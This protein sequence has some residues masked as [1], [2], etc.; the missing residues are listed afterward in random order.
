MVSNAFPTAMVNNKNS[1]QRILTAALVLFV[2]ACSKK[3]ENEINPPLPEALK[4]NYN[5]STYCH[6]DGCKA[7]IQLITYKSKNYFA[8][9]YDQGPLCDLAP[10]SLPIY[11]ENGNE[12]DTDTDLYKDVSTKGHHGDRIWQCTVH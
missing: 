5:D 8:L 12:I 4:K 2:L 10:I 11:D 7:Y 1:M 6:P 3:N 9:G